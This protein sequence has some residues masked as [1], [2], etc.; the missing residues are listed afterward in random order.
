MNLTKILEM[1]VTFCGHS[2]FRPSERCEGWLRSVLDAAIG[3]LPAS[4]Y[5]GGCG[6]FDS[7]A[8]TYGKTY[9]Q[10]HPHVRLVLVTP[11]PSPTT[12]QQRREAS[13]CDEI[14]YPGLE[15]V[16]PRFAIV[17][18]NRYLVDCA[19]LVIAYVTH[20]W[21]GAYRTLRYARAKGKPIVNLA[22]W[23]HTAG[24][25]TP[26]TQNGGIIMRTT[27]QH[28]QTFLHTVSAFA[29]KDSSANYFVRHIFA[30]LREHPELLSN[31]EYRRLYDE[32]LDFQVE[33]TMRHSEW[34]PD[35]WER[36]RR[37][38]EFV[39][40]LANHSQGNFEKFSK[41]LVDHFLAR[42][43]EDWS[44]EDWNREDWNRENKSRED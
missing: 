14:L 32:T 15:N 21:G 42:R 28:R 19:Q 18:R 9:R 36:C 33:C 37:T 34:E 1:I 41:D 5:L 22:D 7:F 3:H 27:K 17:H 13:G 25:R 26:K 39:V 12:P 35:E 23:E 20:D 2:D 24:L 4:L 40:D 29:G 16:P 30:F 8:Y 44:R 43:R 38:T 31:P 6:S 11:Y 10:S